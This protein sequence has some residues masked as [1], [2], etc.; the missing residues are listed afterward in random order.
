MY[1]NNIQSIFPEFN[2]RDDVNALNDKSR[3]ARD[4]AYRNL[5]KSK[6]FGLEYCDRAMKCG[7]YGIPLIAPYYGDLPEYFVSISSPSCLNPAKTCLTCFDYDYVLE[8]LWANPYKYVDLVNTYLCFGSPDF[9]MKVDNPLCVQIANAYR[10]H[11][12]A[13][14][15]QEHGG[16]TMPCMAWSS[17][18]SYEFCFDGYS[19][20]GAVLVS[21]VGTHRDERS[22]LYFKNGFLEMLKRINPDVVI[23]YGDSGKDAYPWLPGMLEVVYVIPDRFKRARSHG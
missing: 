15:F 18:V 12:L 23:L 13:F 10:N 8:R 21:S 4:K 16:V 11:S 7:K 19:K 5:Q 3:K 20:G 22:Q 1:N 2:V 6:N 14:F 17:T 9:S